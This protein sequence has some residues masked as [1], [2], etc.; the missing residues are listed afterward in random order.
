MRESIERVVTVPDC[1][2]VAFLQLL[3]YMY[4]DG[5]T[6]SIDDVVELWWVFAD[7]YQLEGLKLSCLGSLEM[8]LSEDNV[9]QILEDV[10]KL[11]CPCDVL[12]R[13]CQHF[14]EGAISKD[15][16]LDFWCLAYLYQM[17]ALKVRYINIEIYVGEEVE[18]CA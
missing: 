10:E 1:S 7:M 6:V 15:N 18:R 4:M 17:E 11:I 9:G 16:V 5:Y 14:L 8:H 2:K 12:K 3:R 13:M